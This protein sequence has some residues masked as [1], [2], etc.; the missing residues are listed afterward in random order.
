MEMEEDI[1]TI[2]EEGY[3]I[4]SGPSRDERMWAMGC[5]ISTF[6]G[7]VFPFGN[8]IAPLV[9]WLIKKEE[10]EF[11]GDQGKEALNFQ[12]SLT[13]YIAISAVLVLLIIGIPMLIGLV[14]FDFI[15]T[16]IAAIRAADGVRYR[17]PMTMHL[18]K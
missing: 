11:I 15:V 5:H 1:V 18:V 2:E 12:I 9:I 17:Y 13:I 16:V 14:L 10:S 4:E 6:F 8:I 3:E 7:W